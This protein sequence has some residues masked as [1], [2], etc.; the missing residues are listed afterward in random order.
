MLIMVTL[1]A[2]ALVYF[3]TRPNG[4]ETARFWGL[5]YVMAA[6]LANGLNH[7]GMAIITQAYV[8]GVITGLVLL[9]PYSLYLI[10]QAQAAYAIKM[11]TLLWAL[12]TGVALL[13]PIILATRFLATWL[14]A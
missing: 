5:V 9:V 13:L 10:R 7:L 14:L 4:K 3:A 8:P 11:P 6:L 1:L 12:I 2:L